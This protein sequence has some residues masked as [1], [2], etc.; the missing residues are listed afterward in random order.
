MLIFFHFKRYC[1]D[2]LNQGHI[3]PK[4]IYFFLKF[5]KEKFGLPQVD[6]LT[7]YWHWSA[8]KVSIYTH[9]HMH[10]HKHKVARTHRKGLSLSLF[11]PSVWPRALQCWVR[12]ISLQ[13]LKLLHLDTHTNKETH[14]HAYSSA[15]LS[16]L[17]GIVRDPESKLVRGQMWDFCA[18]QM[19]KLSL[20]SLYVCVCVCLPGNATLPVCLE[21]SWKKKRK[22]DDNGLTKSVFQMFVTNKNCVTK[23]KHCACCAKTYLFK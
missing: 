7:L 3:F 6:L 21:T 4:Q 10:T 19:W 2:F 15:T 1:T 9:K 14:V 23:E 17:S 16:C 18:D 12:S 11:F 20:C 13:S 22:V 8:A 5:E